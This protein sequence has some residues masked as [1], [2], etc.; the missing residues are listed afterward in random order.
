M[1]ES[2]SMSANHGFFIAFH[3][4]CFR[5]RK[6]IDGLIDGLILI[7]QEEIMATSPQGTQTGS[8]NPALSGAK[9]TQTIIST[10]YTC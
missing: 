2:L 3:H 7:V 10:A 4:N 8:I 9:L 5:M 1:H 6:H